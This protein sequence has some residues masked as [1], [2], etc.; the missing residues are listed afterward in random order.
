MQVD[1]KWVEDAAAL[2]FASMI[3]LF[4]CSAGFA[5]YWWVVA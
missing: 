3:I 5:L 1:D 4:V 2:V